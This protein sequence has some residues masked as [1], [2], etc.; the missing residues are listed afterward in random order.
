[1]PHRR[2]VEAFELAQGE[3]SLA[4]VCRDEC[5]QQWFEIIVRKVNPSLSNSPWMRGAPQLMLSPAIRLIRH[6]TGSCT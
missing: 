3:A 5:Y 1:L 6:A 2:F 4:G